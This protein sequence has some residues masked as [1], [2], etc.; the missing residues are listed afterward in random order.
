MS[1]TERMRAGKTSVAASSPRPT[2]RV[3][4]GDSPNSR[5]VMREPSL[6]RWRAHSLG[7]LEG[8]TPLHPYVAVKENDL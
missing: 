6:P 4:L 5:T 8:Q 1:L 2:E 3:V 7:L